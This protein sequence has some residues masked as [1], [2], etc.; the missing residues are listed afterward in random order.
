M[1]FDDKKLEELLPQWKENVADHRLPSWENIPNLGLYM[2]QVVTYIRD[3]IGYTNVGPEGTDIITA[4]AINNYV[5]KKL[6]PAPVK[7]RY[8]RKHIA[9]LLVLCTLKQSLTISEIYKLFPDE[10]AD[11]D[12]RIFYSAFANQHV[13]ASQYFMRRL[14]HD[15]NRFLKID[16]GDTPYDRISEFI[17][18]MALISSFAKL[19][20]AK[21]IE[22]KSTE[23]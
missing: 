8:Y 17:L 4:S 6:M 20:S 15:G 23:E 5:R 14:E 22:Y 18:D 16:Q 1:D 11:E 12:L 3:Q 9:Y 2:E 7:K 21:L 19:V 10:V 13:L